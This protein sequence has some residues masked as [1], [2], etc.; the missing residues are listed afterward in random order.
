MKDIVLLYIIFVFSLL[1]PQHLQAKVQIAHMT[2]KEIYDKANFYSK[3]NKIDSAVVLYSY[4]YSQYRNKQSELDKRLSAS[5]CMRLGEIYFDEGRYNNALEILIQGLNISQNCA[6]K[7]MTP[8]FYFLI[9]NIYCCSYE[10]DF[11]KAINCYNKGYEIYKRLGLEDRNTEYKLVKNLSITYNYLNMPDSARKYYA[12][13]TAATTPS[14][15]IMIF[16]NNIIKGL[17]LRN[18]KK[19]KEA[20][21]TFHECIDFIGKNKIDEKYLC[22]TYEELYCLYNMAGRN[23]STLYYLDRCNALALKYN[24]TYLVIQNMKVYSEIYKDMN[25]LEKSL[26]YKDR[27]LSLTDSIFNQREFNRIKN[28]Q[29]IFEKGQHEK[30]ISILSL[31]KEKRD[32]QIRL[33]RQVILIIIAGVVVLVAFLFVLY[34]GKMKLARAYKNIFNVNNEIVESEKHYRMLV[35]QYEKKL[36]EMKSAVMTDGGES[37]QEAVE[38][39]DKQYANTISSKEKKQELVDAVNRIMTSTDEYCKPD[40]SL[41]KLASLVN[42]NSAY[43]SQII[44]ETYK[45]NFSAYLNEFRIKEA[46]ARLA[47]FDNYGNYTIKAIYESVG[48]R[49]NSTFINSFKNIVGI[50]PSTFHKMVKEEYERRNGGSCDGDNE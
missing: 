21:A 12:L 5:S 41:D 20:A 44:N 46:R 48:Y 23:D 10:L 27:Y 32:L 6:K 25:N 33:Q 9:G 35:D 42:S 24:M 2:N 8:D 49:S 4:L 40:F 7:D 30:E 43:V 26:Y 29:Y 22:A 11:E 1:F 15:T 34:R 18:E 28:S 47:D 36:E 14:D 45:K 37:R 31:E 50:T 19:Y 17:I 3:N 38:Q 13:S 39:N 16:Q